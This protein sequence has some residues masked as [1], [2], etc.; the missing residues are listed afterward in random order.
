MVFIVFSVFLIKIVLS[1]I[2]VQARANEIIFH[3]KKI[4]LLKKGTGKGGGE[5]AY[6]CLGASFNFLFV[7]IAVRLLCNILRVEHGNDTLILLRSFP[8]LYKQY[9]N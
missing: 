3:Y 9:K 5:R 8:N 2:F 7:R 6:G 4:I 1:Y